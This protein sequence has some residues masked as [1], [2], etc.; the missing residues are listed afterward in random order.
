MKS[1][2]EEPYIRIRYV[3]I[4]NGC[5]KMERG[6][7]CKNFNFEI[8]VLLDIKYQLESTGIVWKRLQYIRTWFLWRFEH[9]FENQSRSSISM[10]IL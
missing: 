8:C 7:W 2:L 4:Y 5:V 1:S 3:G 9:N 6:N 10:F